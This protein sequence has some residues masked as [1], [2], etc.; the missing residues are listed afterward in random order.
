MDK[1]SE[2]IIR[3]KLLQRIKEA[4]SQ[5]QFAEMHGLA[6]AYVCDMANGRKGFSER[7]L[8]ILGFVVDY[9]EID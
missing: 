9:V 1:K 4:G 5:K 6:M 8:K 3:K 2:K 7:M